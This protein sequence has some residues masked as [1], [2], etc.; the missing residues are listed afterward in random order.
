MYSKPRPV[1]KYTVTATN[2]LNNVV[3]KGHG[4]STC[5]AAQRCVGA[6]FTGPNKSQDGQSVSVTLTVTV[7]R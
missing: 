1:P 6:L 7:N 4:S 3:S 2:F 5:V